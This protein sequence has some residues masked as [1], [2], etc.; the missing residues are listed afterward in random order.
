[1]L[2]PAV[3]NFELAEVYRREI[4]NSVTREL[5]GLVFSQLVHRWYAGERPEGAF[6]ALFFVKTIEASLASHEVVSA[7]LRGESILWPETERQKSDAERSIGS[8]R[9]S[10]RPQE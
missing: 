6:D 7:I 9:H 3:L 10:Q 4:A 2:P 1:M 5:V 8:V